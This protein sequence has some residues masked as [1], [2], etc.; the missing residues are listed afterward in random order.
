[1]AAAHRRAP[2]LNCGLRNLGTAIQLLT[3]ISLQSVAEL[4]PEDEDDGTQDMLLAQHYKDISE[5]CAQ[6]KVDPERMNPRG[7]K[8][9]G[10]GGTNWQGDLVDG[11]NRGGLPYYCPE[12]WQRFSLNVCRDDEFDWWFDGWGYLYHGT[13]GKHVG[14]ILTAGLRGSEGLCFCGKDESAVY[15][16]P[17]IEYSGHPRYACVEYNPETRC[18]IQ[19]VLQCRVNPRCIWKRGRETLKCADFNLQIDRNHSNDDMEYLFKPNYTDPETG[20]KYLK[21]A[22]VCTGGGVEQQDQG[23]DCIDDVHGLV[24]KHGR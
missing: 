2:D 11:R 7:N 22:V 20:F 5:V 21:G 15:F 12:G 4:V 3:D 16:S 19:I 9:Y 23:T 18:W 6:L 24:C 17:S 10:V 13:K 8:S 14:S 1:M